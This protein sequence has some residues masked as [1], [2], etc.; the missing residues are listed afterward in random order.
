MTPKLLQITE[1]L[2]QARKVREVQQGRRKKVCNQYRK[3]APHYIPGD[4]VLVKDHA[5]SNAAKGVTIN[6][7]PRQDWLYTIIP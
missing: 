1:A 6:L 4:L 3:P 2:H 5:L 7:A